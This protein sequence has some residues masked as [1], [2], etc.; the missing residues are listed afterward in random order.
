MPDY[1]DEK[2]NEMLYGSAG[3]LA[4]GEFDRLVSKYTKRVFRRW[5]RTRTRCPLCGVQTRQR[6][7]NDHLMKRCHPQFE[8]KGLSAFLSR[9]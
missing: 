9:D 3:P 2:L 1:V 4:S 7:L 5:L 8:F 6:R